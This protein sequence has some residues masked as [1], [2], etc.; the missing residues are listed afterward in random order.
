MSSEKLSL[1]L[2]V[3]SLH[4]RLKIGTRKIKKGVLKNNVIKFA[5]KEQAELGLERD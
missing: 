2:L 3:F 5:Y 4:Y 1:W